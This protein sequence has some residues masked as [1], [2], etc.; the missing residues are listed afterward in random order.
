MRPS[1][2][3][4]ALLITGPAVV[5]RAADPATNVAIRVTVEDGFRRG[6]GMIKERVNLMD[7]LAE[8]QVSRLDR[9]GWLVQVKCPADVPT[10]GLTVFVGDAGDHKITLMSTNSDA[11]Q[12]L[13]SGT[14]TTPEKGVKI[15]PEAAFRQGLKA[16][17]KWWKVSLGA[18]SSPEGRITLIRTG[19]DEWQMGVY[20]YSETGYREWWIR[21]GDN[22][23]VDARPVSGLGL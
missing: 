11:L 5:T 2:I 17:E 20:G 9:A 10:P 8:F 6:L 1:V 21:I 3:L 19:Q 18:F 7:P 4:F 14:A 15:R 23:E 22:N 12:W 13:A 16:L